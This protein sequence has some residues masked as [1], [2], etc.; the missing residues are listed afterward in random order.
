MFLRCFLRFHKSPS[1]DQAMVLAVHMPLSVFPRE[2]TEVATG[3]GR[4]G[5]YTA[6][7]GTTRMCLVTSSAYAPGPRALRG[8][9]VSCPRGTSPELP[10]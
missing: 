1:L 3:K 7:L 5:L 9:L 8:H 4:P 6:E 10:C 2:R